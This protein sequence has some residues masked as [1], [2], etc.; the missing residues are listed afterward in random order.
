MFFTPEVFERIP[1]G[2]DV[3]TIAH[4]LDAKFLSKYACY[5]NGNLMGGDVADFMSEQTSKLVIILKECE[6]QAAYIDPRSTEGE[7]IVFRIVDYVEAVMSAGWRKLRQ[8]MLAQLLQVA[9]WIFNLVVG[10]DVFVIKNLS[11]PCFLLFREHVLF[12]FYLE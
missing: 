10:L 12:F 3:T 9:V 5:V 1:F 8:D 4:L 11:Q 6:E 2:E 7:S